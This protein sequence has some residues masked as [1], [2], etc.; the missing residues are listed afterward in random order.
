MHLHRKC[1]NMFDSSF[2]L[3][4][5]RIGFCLIVDYARERLGCLELQYYSPKDTRECY[6]LLIPLPEVVSPNRG[7]RASRMVLTSIIKTD[8]VFDGTSLLFVLRLILDI[9]RCY[10][11]NLSPMNSIC[12]IPDTTA[13]SHT[14]WLI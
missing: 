9:W 14:A 8:P 5:S 6:F 4:E 11:A 3:M 10:R 7:V 1:V 13:R 12:W 2:Q